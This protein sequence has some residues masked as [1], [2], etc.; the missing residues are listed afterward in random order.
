MS[1]PLVS[2]PLVSGSLFRVRSERRVAALASALVLDR[3]LGEPPDRYHPVALFGRGMSRLEEGMWADR[4]SVGTLYTT[5]GVAAAALTGAALSGA[6]ATRSRSTR[7]SGGRRWAALAAATWV[8]VAGRALE[9]AAGVVDRALAAN[10][11]DRAR[12][13]LRSLVGRRTDDLDEEGIVRAVVES[14]AE[15]TVDAVTAPLLWAALGGAPAVLAYRAVNTLD[16]MVGHRS[17]RHE[18]FGWASART[19]DV[20]NW[21]PARLTALLVAAVR[22][23]RA[24]AVRRAVAEQA[25]AHPSPN[26][27]VVEAA[28]AAAL[29]LRLGGVN[30]YA[31][32]I[33]DRPLLGWGR[34]PA[35]ADIGAACRLSRHVTAALI[36]VLW[37]AGRRPPVAGRPVEAQ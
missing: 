36:A 15:N 19:D 14:V 35:R 27:G 5:G 2:V 17:P 32:R 29:G 7:G 6:R 1:V 10:D 18:R 3:L 20:A 12:R 4:R 11:L 21:I 26:A 33:E 22:P 37:V 34:S 25:P 28:F 31:G 30:N 8:A 13:D 16:A 9:E 23:H 24:G